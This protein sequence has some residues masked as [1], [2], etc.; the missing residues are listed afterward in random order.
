MRTLLSERYAPIT[1]AIGFLEVPLDVAA[2]ALERWRRGHLD[3]T[4]TPLTNRSP[5]CST[6]WSR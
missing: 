1:S 3:A 2:G 6:D 5:R 4:A